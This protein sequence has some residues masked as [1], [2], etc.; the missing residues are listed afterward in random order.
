MGMIFQ[1]C[2]TDKSEEQAQPELDAVIEALDDYLMN[3]TPT[4]PITL[5]KH[6]SDSDACSAEL[7]EVISAG[8]K[9]LGP[10]HG[11]K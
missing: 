9:E 8:L 1:S 10:E 2:L 3:K 6:F 11:E 4:P 7:K 5:L